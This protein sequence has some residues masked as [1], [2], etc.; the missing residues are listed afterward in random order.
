MTYL[1]RLENGENARVLL[2]EASGVIQEQKDSLDTVLSLSNACIDQHGVLK[3]IRDTILE[4][5]ENIKNG[6]I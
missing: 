3:D 5:E 4:C 2:L 6:D 1:E